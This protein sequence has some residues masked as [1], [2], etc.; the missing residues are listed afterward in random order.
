LYLPLRGG[1]GVGRVQY[2][3]DGGV[4]EG[5]GVAREE[6]GGGERGGLDE[7]RHG[8][9]LLV[10]DSNA[11]SPFHPMMAIGRSSISTFHSEFRSL[12]GFQ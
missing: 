11:V 9:A 4:G 6:A 1:E 3:G 7:G 2:D 10:F 12:L 5:P 8:D